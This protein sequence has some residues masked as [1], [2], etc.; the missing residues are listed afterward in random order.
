MTHEE[1]I[2]SFIR[3]LADLAECGESF[4]FFTYGKTD[5]E[6]DNASSDNSTEENP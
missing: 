1:Y 4:D 5:G 6:N 2:K 3:T